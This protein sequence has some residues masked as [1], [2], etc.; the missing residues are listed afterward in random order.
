M[1]KSQRRVTGVNAQR[2]RRVYRDGQSDGKTRNVLAGPMTTE[3]DWELLGRLFAD[4]GAD[5]RHQMGLAR[6]D[7]GVF[8]APSTAAAAIRAQKQAV[9]S[10]PAAALH[11]LETSEGGPIFRE[12]ARTVGVGADSTNQRAVTLA[13]EPDYLLMAPQP[14]RLAWASVCF[15][16]RWSLKGK[17]GCPLA[18]IH[19]PVPGLNDALGRKIDRFFDRLVP[20]EGWGRANWGLST[21]ANAN[22][23][24]RLPYT[25]LSCQTSLDTVFVRLESQHLLKLPATGAV[26]FGI[27]I[28]HFALVEAARRTG[29]AAGLTTRLRTMPAEVAAYKGIPTDFWRR[30]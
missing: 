30:L 13:L 1:E 7:P 16:T 2:E 12:F 23:H 15:P 21:N 4:D 8:Y 22:Q 24:P 17:G 10:S 18:E 29:I 11:L 26:A 3:A 9:L 20:G 28:L 27:R 14:W 6:S 5:F 19:S 25:P